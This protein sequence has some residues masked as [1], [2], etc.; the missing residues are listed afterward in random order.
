MKITKKTVFTTIKLGISSM[1]LVSIL[2]S[3]GCLVDTGSD[4]TDPIP[5]SQKNIH[6]Y[7]PG[8][9]IRYDVQ[10]DV[11]KGTLVTRWD[12]PVLEEIVDANPVEPP[13]NE[14]IKGLLKETTTFEH[15][16]STER[17]VVV[18]YITQ[19]KDENSLDYGAI[20]VHAFDSPSGP[21]LHHYVHE[22][23]TSLVSPGPPIPAKIIPSPLPLDDNFEPIAGQSDLDINYYVLPCDHINNT[24]QL[25]NQQL[26]ETLSLSKMIKENLETT[27]DYL[28]TIKVP[29]IGNITDP[30]SSAVS[31]VRLD[32]RAFCGDVNDANIGYTGA[33]WFFP[34]IGIVRYEVT[35][36]SSSETQ[37]LA[38]TV[39]SVNFSY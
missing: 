26:T 15:E 11:F 1:V 35:C 32:I 31:G 38:A 6:I 19:E 33:E 13:S 18:R 37:I 5:I 4:V 7:S 17:V 20:T 21:A 9:E 2:G 30:T 39:S 10:Y 14:V 28:Q 36:T 3:S 23:S 12:L 29:F 16:G 25:A 27:L 22:G 8:D 24:C 34:S